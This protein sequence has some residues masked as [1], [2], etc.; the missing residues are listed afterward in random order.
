ML[1]STGWRFALTFFCCRG[2]RG[3]RIPIRKCPKRD[4]V[5]V[6]LTQEL[7]RCLRR[8]RLDDRADEGAVEA[9]IDVGDAG[10]RADTSVIAPQPGLCA[11]PKITTE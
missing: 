3:M 1:A 4:P 9:L 8:Q 5:R 2:D 11:A 7:R 6:H 10:E